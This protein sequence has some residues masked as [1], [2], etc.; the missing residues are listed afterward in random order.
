[1]G[2]QLYD[3]EWYGSLLNCRAC[4]CRDEARR[5]VPGVGPREAEIMIIGQNPGSDEDVEGVP[6]IGAGGQELDRWLRVLGL[7]RD[8]IIVT[9]AVL[10]HTDR[11]RVPNRFE[12]VT[13]RDQ[14]MGKTLAFCTQVQV[15]VPLG[16]PALE[17]VVGRQRTTF[18]A[19]TPW[20]FTTEFEGRTLHVT[21]LAHPAYLLRAPSQKGVMY[22]TVL[23]AVREYLERVVP[24]VCARAR[25]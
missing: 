20:W 13:C 5:P 23:P 18:G 15:L 7:R 16:R 4:S 17:S 8:R 10:C 25:V 22:R 21:P 19:L 9:N 11:N 24:D 2:Q 3:A 12:I 6:F 1:M 14:W